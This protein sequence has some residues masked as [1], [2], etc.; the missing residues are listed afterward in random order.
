MTTTEWRNIPSFPDYQASTEGTIRRVTPRAN[1]HRLEPSL[2]G[3]VM[4]G[5]G[6]FTITIT[7]PGGKRRNVCV[8]KLICLA[9]HGPKPTPQHEVAHGD[10][11]RT[12]N[13]P[14]N[15]RWA[16]HSEN[17]QDRVRH[18]RDRCGAD[19]HAA[20]LADDNIDLIFYLA[21]RG[22]G[23]RQIAS[24]FQVSQRT[25]WRVLNGKSWRHVEHDRSFN[26][27]TGPLL[28]AAR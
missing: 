18:G 14:D 27:E 25:I 13:R 3:Y 7:F 5:T 8:H 1:G 17:M 21:E 9:F 24:L 15:L 2:N 19:N 4:K 6:Y 26:L 16:T 28:A 10:G 11:T 22:F 23:Q 20:K 12:N